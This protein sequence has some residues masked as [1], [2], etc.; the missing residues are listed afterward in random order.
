VLRGVT[1]CGGRV[2]DQLPLHRGDVPAVVTGR[3]LG[4]SVMRLS[5][6]A[7]TRVVR[8]A[9]GPGRSRRG[10]PGQGVCGWMSLQRL[11]R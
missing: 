2:F 3:E 1:G 9:R 10:Q 11:L 7:S 4:F 5:E 6:T 8:P